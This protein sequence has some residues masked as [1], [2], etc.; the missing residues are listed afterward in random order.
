MPYA[1][2]YVAVGIE[3]LVAT[4]LLHRAPAHPF[5]GVKMAKYQMFFD[6]SKAVHELGLPQSPVDEALRRAVV[7]FRA[8]GYVK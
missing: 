8:N 1:V 2:A 6:A 3:N 5:E 4:K 7:W